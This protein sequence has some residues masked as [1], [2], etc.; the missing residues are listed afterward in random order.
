MKVTF[1]T[2]NFS[3][4]ITKTVNEMFG[5]KAATIPARTLTHPPITP[6]ATT[7]PSLAKSLTKGHKK[8]E[9][10]PCKSAVHRRKAAND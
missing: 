6:F 9:K 2:T 3:P 10:E 1:S 7:K 8:Y 4:T 5:T